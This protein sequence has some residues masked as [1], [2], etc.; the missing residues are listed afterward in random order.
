MKNQ[1]LFII[2]FLI[3]DFSNAQRVIEENDFNIL[4]Y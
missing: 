2:L 1:L 3:S 4:E